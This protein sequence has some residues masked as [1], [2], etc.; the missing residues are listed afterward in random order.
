[1]HLRIPIAAGLSLAALAFVTPASAQ[2]EEDH[3]NLTIG[4]GVAVVPTYEG[5][6]DYRVLPF[7]QARGKVHDFAFWTRGPSLFI[8]A[9]PN[10]DSSGLDLQLGPVAAVRFDR[11]SWK[12]IRDSQVRA[13]GERDVAVELGGFA[14]IGKTGVITSAYDNITARV[15]VT[16]D[17][18]G[19]HKGVVVTPAIEYFTP[20]SVKSFVGLSVSG[21]WVSKRYGAYYFDID[22][23]GALASGLP[24]Y[25]RAGDKSGFKRVGLN[26]TGGYSLSGDLRRGWAIVALASYNRMLGRYGDSPVVDIAGS[27]NQWIGAIGI[28]YTF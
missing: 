1:M 15:A 14:G 12:A 5:S 2:Q 8:D 23:A 11:S 18:A 13:L 4:A 27:R 25:D 22:P 19:A 20:L 3:S 17:V 21:E 9:I 10:T 24:V 26:L 16:K 28:G 6:D 7:P